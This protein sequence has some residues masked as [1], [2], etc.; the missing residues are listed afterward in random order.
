MIVNYDLNVAGAA[1]LEKEMTTA[2]PEP[3]GELI[4]DLSGCNFVA[5]SGLR[6]LLKKAQ[7]LARDGGSLVL[8]GTN[9]TVRKAMQISGF[10]TL[11]EI[12]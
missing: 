7:I 2:V 5:S 9:D 11:M 6:V 3:N 10:D 8:I 4:I 12:R 1:K